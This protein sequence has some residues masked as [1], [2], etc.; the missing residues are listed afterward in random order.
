MTIIDELIRRE[1]SAYTNHPEDR[2]GPTKFGIT[3]A[4]LSAS[5]GRPVTPRDVELLEEVEARA[6][7]ERRYVQDPGFWRINSPALRELIVD[8][9]V[10]HG[11]TRAAKWLQSVVGAKPDGLVGRVTATL[12]NENPP[13]QVFAKVLCTRLRFYEDLDDQ[14]GQAKFDM[15]WTNRCCEFVMLLASM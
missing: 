9:G 13:K 7:Y 10:N 3:Q 1:G 8:C 15:G 5:R 2:G 4:T 12:V 6:I 11:T 14:P